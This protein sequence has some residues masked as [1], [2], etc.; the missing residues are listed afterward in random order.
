[1]RAVVWSLR[2]RAQASIT[3]VVRVPIVGKVI[4]SNDGNVRRAVSPS[5]CMPACPT[6]GSALLDVTAIHWLVWHDL[7]AG[8]I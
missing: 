1:V 6:N 5:L 3:V 4:A 7:S 8:L 2:R